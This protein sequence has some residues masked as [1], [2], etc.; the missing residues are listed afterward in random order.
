M[1]KLI[2]E[3]IEYP[4]SRSNCILVRTNFENKEVRNTETGHYN[5][6]IR[7]PHRLCIKQVGLRPLDHLTCKSGRYKYIAI[8][9]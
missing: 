2:P 7:K 8:L 9:D 5:G 6:V 4:C 3:C 1:T